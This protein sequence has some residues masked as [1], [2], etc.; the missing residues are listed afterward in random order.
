MQYLEQPDSRGPVKLR[1][2][3]K[4]IKRPII[5]VPFRGRMKWVG[6]RLFFELLLSTAK[7]DDKRKKS[8]LGTP[9]MLHRTHKISR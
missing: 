9:K 7:E 5:T 4:I 1:L 3:L 8:V 6:R 2:P